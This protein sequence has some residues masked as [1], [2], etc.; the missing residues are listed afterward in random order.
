ML[1]F[2]LDVIFTL[3]AVRAIWKLLQGVMQ[4]LSGPSRQ[5]HQAGPRRESGGVPAQGVQMA[6]DPVCGTYVVPDRAVSL[7]MG[8]QT[9]YFC[10]EACRDKYQ[11]KTA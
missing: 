6:R 1:G 3:L 11:A 2:A 10:S 8:R 5:S 7:S 9:T 4:G